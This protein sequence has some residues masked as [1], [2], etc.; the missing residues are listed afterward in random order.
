M[1]CHIFEVR[2]ISR[3]YFTIILALML[4]GKR[5]KHVEEQIEVLG[6]AQLN[7]LYVDFWVL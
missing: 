4:T 6:R 3:R 7:F 1:L 5:K 2:K